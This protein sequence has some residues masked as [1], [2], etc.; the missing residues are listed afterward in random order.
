MEPSLRYQAINNGDVNIVDAYST[1]SQL[2]EYDLVT[3]EDDQ[4]LFPA[5][6]GAPLMKTDFAKDHPEIVEAL[7]KLSGKITE[8]QMIDMNYQVNVEKKK[9]AEVARTFLENEGL[10][11]EGDQ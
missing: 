1:D 11:K 7:N 4:G 6:Q 2:K 9:P 10:L 3:L 5:Y 8:N